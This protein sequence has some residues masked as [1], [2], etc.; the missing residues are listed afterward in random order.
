MQFLYLRYEQH[1]EVVN[2][3]VYERVEIKKQKTTVMIVIG[4]HTTA[5]KLSF[6]FPVCFKTR[7]FYFCDQLKVV[8]TI[9]VI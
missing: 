4:S 8:T 9:I 6:S 1:Q 2:K 7:Y 5:S 3:E